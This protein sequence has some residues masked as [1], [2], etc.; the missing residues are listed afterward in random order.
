M[1]LHL[2]APLA[3]IIFEQAPAGIECVAHGDIGILVRMVRRRVAPDHDLAAGD[4]EVDANVKQITLL[5]PRMPAFED[6][7]TGCNPIEKAF[8]LLGAAADA[9]GDRLRAVHVAKRDLKKRNLHRFLLSAAV[10]D[11]FSDYQRRSRALGSSSIS[12]V[13]NGE[14]DGQSCRRAEPPKT[15]QARLLS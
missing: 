7:A 10:T 3:N 14:T 4:A 6:N 2:F 5:T 8:E 12:S 1:Q 11:A 13:D 9:C 15:Q